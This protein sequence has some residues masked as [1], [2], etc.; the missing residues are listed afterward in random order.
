[1]SR[2]LGRRRRC[3]GRPEEG[4]AAYFAN[5]ATIEAPSNGWLCLSLWRR[6]RRRRPN[7]MTAVKATA[8]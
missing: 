5:S 6:R 2:R 4:A 3:F 8:Y 1:M 7:D